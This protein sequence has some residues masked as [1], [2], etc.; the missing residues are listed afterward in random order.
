MFFD[1][2]HAFD[3]R[4]FY[5]LMVVPQPK[6]KH[7]PRSG[8][9]RIEFDWKIFEQLCAIQ[10]TEIEM[11]A[12]FRCGV[13]TLRRAV[14]RQYGKTFDEV[15]E[16]KKGIGRISLRRMQ[17]HKAQD[18]AVMQIWLGKQLLGQKD[19][20][21]GPVGHEIV[22]RVEYGQKGD[23]ESRPGIGNGELGVH[24]PLA[25]SV[26]HAAPGHREQGEA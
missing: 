17:F 1:F 16:E 3:E 5:P 6:K 11:M 24:G 4:P 22:I 19:R 21:E 25:E 20:I 10:C 12:W 8:R 2:S 26:G 15:Y 13:E 18:N 14:K 7:K 9:P 23:G